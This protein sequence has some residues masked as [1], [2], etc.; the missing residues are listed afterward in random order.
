MILLTDKSIIPPLFNGCE[1]LSK[2]E[3]FASE[4]Q[5][6][7][8]HVVLYLLSLLELVATYMKLHNI[9]VTLKIVQKLGTTIGSHNASGL[10]CIVVMLL[11]N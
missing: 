11:K 7:L 9:S 3:L 2:L 5:I 10:D 6:L 8:S 1:F 4:T